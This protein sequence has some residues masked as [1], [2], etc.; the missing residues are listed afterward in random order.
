MLIDATGLLESGRRPMLEF[1]LFLFYGAN[2]D[3][4]EGLMNPAT[5][6]NAQRVT[7]SA[8]QITDADGV[9]RRFTEVVRASFLEEHSIELA[10]SGGAADWNCALHRRR[11]HVAGESG[12]GSG[13][14]V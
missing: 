10:S 13:D 4:L 7:L 14:G 9:D 8:Q 12:S 3:V 11:R 6:P 2:K 1:L 5:Q